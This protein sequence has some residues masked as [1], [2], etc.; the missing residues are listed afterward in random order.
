MDEFAE[1]IAALDKVVILVEALA[2]GSEQDC[3]S[4]LSDLDG[5]LESL[6]K[7]VN[8]NGALREKLG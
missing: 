3:V 6:R 4:W 8:D 2:T 5:S 1:R 7:V